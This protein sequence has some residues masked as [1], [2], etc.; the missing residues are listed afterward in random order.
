MCIWT[1]WWETVSLV[2]EKRKSTLHLSSHFTIVFLFVSFDSA[3]HSHKHTEKWKTVESSLL[4][5]LEP[6]YHLA[7]A[8]TPDCARITYSHF[9]DSKRAKIADIYFDLDLKLCNKCVCMLMVALLQHITPL[10]A[11]LKKYISLT[12]CAFM[13]TISRE[14]ISLM[15]EQSKRPHVCTWMRMCSNE[16]RGMQNGKALIH[17]NFLWHVIRK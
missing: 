15:V 10:I 5:A 11:T 7:A 4:W 3:T 6:Q 9:S 12:L 13:P 17:T 8:R 2:D 14:A 16:L 1:V